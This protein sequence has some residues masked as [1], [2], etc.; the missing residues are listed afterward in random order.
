VAVYIPAGKR[1]RRIALLVVG[2]LALGM[3]LGVL[4]GRATAP[5]YSDG[6]ASGRQAGADVVIALDSLPI[7]Y[8]GTVQGAAGKSP[9]VFDASLSRIDMMLNDA[10]AKAKWFGPVGTGRLQ[11]AVAILRRDTAAK[12][13]PAQ[14]AADV[15]TVVTTI[16]GEFGLPGSGA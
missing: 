16:Q 8:S 6:V 11:A 13:D 2:G 7:E 1:R 12:V 4:I 9:Q 3:L 10:I 14:F 5:S 15:K